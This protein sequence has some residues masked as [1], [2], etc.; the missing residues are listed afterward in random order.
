MED[1]G[2]E[3]YSRLR[4]IPLVVQCDNEDVIVFF[5]KLIFGNWQL[6]RA[7][8]K[9]RQLVGDSFIVKQNRHY[10]FTQVP[11]CCKKNTLIAVFIIQ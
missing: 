9:M 6:K 1:P 2:D 7:L 4:H 5:L 8:T 10:D 11:Y 3:Y